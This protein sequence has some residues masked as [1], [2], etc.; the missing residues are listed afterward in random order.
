MAVLW[1]A[2]VEY[3]QGYQV[4]EPEVVLAEEPD[5]SA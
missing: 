2:G 1:Q 4:Q 5:H 3:L